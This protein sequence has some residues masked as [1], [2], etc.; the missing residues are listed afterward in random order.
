MA[1]L[2]GEVEEIVAAGEQF[3]HPRRVADIGNLDPHPVFDRRDVEAVAAVIR[4]QTVD[5]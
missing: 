2:A 1:G 5:Q 4:Q 3:A